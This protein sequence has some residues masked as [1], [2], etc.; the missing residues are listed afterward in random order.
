MNQ[1]APRVVTR[2]DAA[3]RL[4]EVAQR[5]FLENGFA[6]TST[7]A[8][9]REARAS[10]ETLYTHFGGKEGL[11]A[12]VLR[13]LIESTEA[14]TRSAAPAQHD[15]GDDLQAYGAALVHDI[16][17]PDYLA[18]ARL[19]IT[20]LPRQPQ[21]GELFRSSLAER[22]FRGSVAILE[23][24]GLADTVN[25]NAVARTFAGGLLTYML[26]DGLLA[27]PRARRPS[28][29]QVRAH[30]DLCLAALS[31]ARRHMESEA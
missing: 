4:R 21:L 6:A 29:Q 8:I 13:H 31:P 17:Q 25:V 14:G 16:M 22:A 27:S 19:V 15:L 12:E 11:F 24:H 7:D 2:S 10:K 30:V 26:I 20:E 18:L 9:C 5:L 28:R 23:R 1:T 3:Q